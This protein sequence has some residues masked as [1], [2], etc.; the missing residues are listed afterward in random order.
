ME[1]AD[2][3][4]SIQPILGAS[5]IAA[6]ALQLAP[7]GKIYKTNLGSS[8][9]SV[10]NNPEADAANVNYSESTSNGAIN[11]NGKLATFGLPPFIQSFFLNTINII[12][13]DDDEIVTELKLCPQE[14][15]TLFYDDLPG[16]TYSWYK[17]G[18]ITCW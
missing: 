8:I 5:G 14:N 12:N 13:G 15:Y 7:N 17:N 9:L 18:E 2:I 4:N 16:A 1:S 10:I 11:L 6:T 3:P